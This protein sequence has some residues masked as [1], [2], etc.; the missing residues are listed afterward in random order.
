MPC[1]LYSAYSLDGFFPYLAQMNTSMRGCVALSDL[2]PW[3]I[4]SKAFSH[5]P[6]Y[7]LPAM[8]GIRYELILWVIMGSGGILNHKRSGYICL[9][10]TSNISLLFHVA[11]NY[12]FAINPRFV[13]TTKVVLGFENVMK[14]TGVA[15]L[16]IKAR[17]VRWGIQ[18]VFSH[19]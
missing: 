1:P 19:D 4:L 13:K 18:T 2:L 5:D 7:L 8:N 10:D 9:S 14:H 6:F 11:F 3:S 17:E 16:N 12:P 15:V